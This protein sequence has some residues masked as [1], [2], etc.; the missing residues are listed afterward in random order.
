[1]AVEEVLSEL[2]G[3][4]LGDHEHALALI[5]FCQLLG[6]DLLLL[7]FDVIFLCQPAE[8]LGV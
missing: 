7:N 4:I 8:S 5:L 3:G 1:M 6:G 2:P